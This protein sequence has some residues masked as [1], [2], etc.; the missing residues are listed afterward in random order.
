MP[1]NKI[2][3]LCKINLWPCAVVDS[4]GVEDEGRRWVE[5]RD[6]CGVEDEGWR[7]AEVGEKMKI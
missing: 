1:I 6:S 5:V 7:W 3:I 4:C 2:Q